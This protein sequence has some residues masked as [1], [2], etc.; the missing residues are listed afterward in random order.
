MKHLGFLF[1]LKW[2]NRLFVKTHF[3]PNTI[4]IKKF[5]SHINNEIVELSCLRSLLCAI[6]HQYMSISNHPN[7]L[8]KSLSNQRVESEIEERI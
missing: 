3:S 5:F 7:E 4:T 6:F 2:K 8:S 1:L